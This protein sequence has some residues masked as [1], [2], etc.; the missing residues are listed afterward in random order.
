[1]KTK[2]LFSIKKAVAFL[3]LICAASSSF[4]QMSYEEYQER[5]KPH[6]EKLT[7]NAKLVTTVNDSEISVGAAVI[8]LL[9]QKL[10][11]NSDDQENKLN[12]VAII[13]SCDR[14]VV[15]K[16]YEGKVVITQSNPLPMHILDIMPLLKESDK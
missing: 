14:A 1:M 2:N 15:A 8:Q 10:D 3:M 11:A 7:P 4:A 9:L 12:L 13:T 5:Y 6:Y 16:I